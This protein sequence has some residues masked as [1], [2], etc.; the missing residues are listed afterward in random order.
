LRNAS[1][2]AGYPCW[3][4]PAQALSPYRSGISHGLA[5]I[6]GRWPPYLRLAGLWRQRARDRALLAQFDDRM[7]PDIG[8]THADVVREIN[9]QFW[10][11]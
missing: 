1:P 5:G 8:L 7:L 6:L 9:R 4:S 11:E 3:G 10:R 2:T